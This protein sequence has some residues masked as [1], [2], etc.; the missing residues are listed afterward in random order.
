MNI[1][2]IARRL[3]DAYALNGV[4]IDPMDLHAARAAARE[5]LRQ[6]N[7]KAK[8]QYHCNYCESACEMIQEARKELR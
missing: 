3:L 5:V 2:R 4:E 6:L 7:A 8:R 1:E